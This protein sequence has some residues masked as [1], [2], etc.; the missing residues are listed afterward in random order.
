MCWK[1][2]EK[3]C[4]YIQGRTLLH[5]PLLLYSFYPFLIFVGHWEEGRTGNLGVLQM[6]Y[7]HNHSPDLCPILPTPKGT[8]RNR[9]D[10]QCRH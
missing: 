10:V 5:F 3:W 4:L 1:N 8:M 6:R 7:S 2:R 9:L